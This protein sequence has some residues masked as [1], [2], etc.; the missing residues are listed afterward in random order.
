MVSLPGVDDQDRALSLVGTTAELRFRPV[1]G[2]SNTARPE[3]TASGSWSGIQAACSEVGSGAVVPAIGT[4]G[5]TDPEDDQIED[6]VVL[7]LRDDTSGQRYLLGPSVLTGEAIADANPLF[8][9]YQ[10]QVGLDLHQGSVGIDGFN[11][12]AARC[13]AGDPTC[14]RVEGSPTAVW[15]LCGRPG[16]DRPVHPGPCVPTRCHPDLRWV[17]EG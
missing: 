10:W 3:A 13:F 15:P 9:D 6:F 2:I 14:P 5:Y 17:R 12:I 7:G 4:N 1:C 16:G 11:D 8:I